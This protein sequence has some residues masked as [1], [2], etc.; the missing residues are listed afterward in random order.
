MT[1]VQPIDASAMANDIDAAPSLEIPS[2]VITE[3]H[4]RDICIAN[5]QSVLQ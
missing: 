4:D 3:T 2:Q 5:L 1:H